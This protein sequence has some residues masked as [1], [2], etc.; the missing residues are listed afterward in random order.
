MNEIDIRVAYLQNTGDLP[1]WAKD[2]RGKVIKKFRSGSDRLKTWQFGY[3]ISDYGRWMEDILGGSKLMRDKYLSETGSF[4][5]YQ[6][7][8]ME[9]LTVNYDYWLEEQILQNPKVLE[10]VNS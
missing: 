6:F 3:P 2:R 5:Y 4:G 8:H 9:V 7:N 10:N 1:L